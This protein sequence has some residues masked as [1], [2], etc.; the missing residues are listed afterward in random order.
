MKVRM[1]AEALSLAFQMTLVTSVLIAAPQNT[2]NSNTSNLDT[3]T[4]RQMNQLATRLLQNVDQARQ[5]ISN[6]QKQTAD[7]HINRALAEWNQ[8]SSLAKSKNAGLIVPM[9]VEFDETSTLGPMIAARKGNQQPNAQQPNTKAAPRSY[10]PVT[11]EQASGQVTFLGLDLDKAKTRL[12]AA[13]TALNNGNTQASS[14][15]LKGVETDLVMNTEQMSFPLLAARE[16]LGIAESAAKN[17]H[18]REA[19]AALKEASTDLNKYAGTS[20]RHADDARNLSKT[21]DSYSQSIG[22][23]HSGAAT[24][25]DGW[26]H[27]VNNWFEQPSRT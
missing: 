20:S 14:D 1:A 22:Q 21:I 9:Y 26:W 27:E 23:N 17:G 13:K 15:S 24:K 19:A 18:E 3:Q 12:D 2:S 25:I 5:D 8:L 11:V 6:N 10:T 16:N 4:V 7:N